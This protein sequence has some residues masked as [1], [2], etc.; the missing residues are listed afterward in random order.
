MSPSDLRE[1]LIRHLFDHDQIVTADPIDD[2][3]PPVIGLVLTSGEM[4]ILTVEDA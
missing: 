1:L 4:F 2:P 3:G